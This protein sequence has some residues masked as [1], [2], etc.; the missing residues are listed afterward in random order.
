MRKFLRTFQSYVPALRPAKQAFY[1]RYRQVLGRP[2]EPDFAALKQLRADTPGVYVDI[3]ANH[4]QSIHSIRVFR[5]SAQIVA[6]EPNPN[7]AGEITRAYSRDSRVEVRALGLGDA[8]GEFT[9]F[10]P[11]YRGFV[12]DGLAS[13]DE[14]EAMTWINPQRV[15]FFDASKVKALELRCR[16]STLDHENLQPAFIKIDVQGFEY[17]VL[18]GGVKTLA[19]HEPIVLIE[20]YNGDPRSVQLMSE[21]GYSEYVYRDGALALGRSAGANSFLITPNRARAEGL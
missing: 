18:A 20:N 11:A 9:L 8:V 14:A 17:N 16:I 1:H 13:L 15:Y 21:L 10:V 12:Y 2:H 7:L 3:G 5:P 4:G 19:A 6:F